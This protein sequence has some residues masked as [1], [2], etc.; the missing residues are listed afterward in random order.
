LTL[1]ERVEVVASEPPTAEQ[2]GRAAMLC[3]VDD[4]RDVDIAVAL[5]ISRRTLAR[6]KRR[7]DFAAAMAAVRSFHRLKPGEAFRGLAPHWR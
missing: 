6:W 7:D 2:I 5:G 1:R 3:D 4:L